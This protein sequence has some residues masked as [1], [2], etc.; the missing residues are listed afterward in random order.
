VQPALTGRAF[1]KLAAKHMNA[2][3]KVMVLPK[4]L[5]KVIGWFDPFMKEAYEM[6]YQ[7]EYP[8]RFSS[9]KFEKLPLKPICCTRRL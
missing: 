7:D 9:A 6:N 1:V 3:D 5:L 4:W 2:S 8:F